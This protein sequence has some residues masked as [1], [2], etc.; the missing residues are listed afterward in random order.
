MD[1]C[2]YTYIY[3]CVYV[4]VSACVFVC[5]CAKYVNVIKMKW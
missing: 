4:R 2:M 5:V 3:M 1:R